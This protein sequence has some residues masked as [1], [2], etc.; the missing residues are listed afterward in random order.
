MT[1]RPQWKTERDFAKPAA[2]LWRLNLIFGAIEQWTQTRTKFEA[3]AILNELD[4]PCGPVLS[5][6]EL[7]ED[8]A[9]YASG[10]LAEVEHPQRGNYITVGSPVKLSDN[11]YAVTRSPLLGEHTGEILAEVLQF[12]PPRY[13]RC[14][15]PAAWARRAFRGSRPAHA[16]FFP[17]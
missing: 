5:M 9:L 2:R 3:L 10:T 6:K 8:P 13:G 7:T 15:P 14:V 1:G 4:I 16:A 17:V 11:Q 12:D